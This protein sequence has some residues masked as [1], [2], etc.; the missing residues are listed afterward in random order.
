MALCD[1]YIHVVPTRPL[2][3][4]DDSWLCRWCRVPFS[5]VDCKYFSKARFRKLLRVKASDGVSTLAPDAKVV[6]AVVDS[7][8]AGPK[9]INPVGPE[10]YKPT[11]DEVNVL[12]DK[13][14]DC[15]F[16]DLAKES[17]HSHSCPACKI[18]FLYLY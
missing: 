5:A 2:R 1:G 12:I 9:P 3:S 17:I 16:S 7:A 15:Y 13:L 18:K 14:V 8:S 11:E 6:G 10:P 4:R